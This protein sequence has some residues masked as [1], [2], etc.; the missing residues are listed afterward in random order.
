MVIEEEEEEEGE[1][2]RTETSWVLLRERWW[3]WRFREK[4]MSLELWVLGV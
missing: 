4:L 1:V 2:L 3:A